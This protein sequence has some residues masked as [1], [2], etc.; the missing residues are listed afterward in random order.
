M[1][2]AEYTKHLRECLFHSRTGG[3]VG[4]RNYLGVGV[5]VGTGVG[6]GVRNSSGVGVRVGTGVGANNL[7]GVDLGVEF[8]V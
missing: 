8:N 6:V 1:Y 2:C 3:G 5:G 4:V 7:L